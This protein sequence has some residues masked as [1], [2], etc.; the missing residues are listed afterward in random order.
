MPH[1]GTYAV[2][3]LPHHQATKDSIFLQGRR[4]PAHPRNQERGTR[5]RRGRALARHGSTETSTLRCHLALEGPCRGAIAGSSTP[6]IELFGTEVRIVGRRADLVEGFITRH[7][8]T[9]RHRAVLM[10]QYTR[11][12]PKLVDYRTCTGS[13][14]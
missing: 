14:G 1:R 2:S 4:L 8:L 11:Y 6:H 3:A 7:R 10:K 13:A 12:W 9:A 5:S